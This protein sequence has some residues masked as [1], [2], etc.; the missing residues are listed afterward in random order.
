MILVTGCTG[1]VGSSL[2][3]HLLKAGKSVRGFARHP[4]VR[5]D[6]AFP[7]IDIHPG[8]V[9]NP[10]QLHAAMEGVTQVIHLV[11]IL[12]EP[13][14]L[15]FDKVHRQGTLNVIEAAQKAGV[16]RYLQMSSLGTRAGAA[17]RYHQSKWLAEEAVRESGLD[18]TIFRPSVIFGPYDD[19]AN[20]FAKLARLSPAVPILGDGKGRMQP[21]WVED[22][23]RF[24]CHTLEAPETIGRTIELGGPDQLTFSQIMDAI[25]K[26]MGKRRLRLRL[27][28]SILNLEAAIVERILQKPP[29]TQDQVIMAQEDNI[30]GQT[31]PWNDFNMIPRGFADG[32]RDYL[33]P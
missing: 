11:G 16:K 33:G 15:T 4:L 30:C 31:P 24:V 18:Y 12:F 20:Q 19:F 5:K 13:K 21:V 27:P 25:L 7:D 23:T 8:S 10:D 6:P 22:V 17:S 1:F 26:A 3:P 29:I 9:L 14:G 2:I 32:I 28:F